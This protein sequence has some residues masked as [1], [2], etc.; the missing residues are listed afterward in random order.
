M[1][2]AL[3]EI[4]RINRKARKL[5]FNVYK[6]PK[7]ERNT[8][9]KK[10]GRLNI[11][12]M[13]LTSKP[14]TIVIIVPVRNRDDAQIIIKKT[15]EDSNTL[16]ILFVKQNM[17]LPFCRGAMLNIGFR[18][19]KRIYPME[20]G[21]ITLVLHDV[22][23]IPLEATSLHRKDL[24]KRWKT[25]SNIVKHIY[26]FQNSLGGIISIIASDFEKING[27]PNIYGW[28]NED[29][30]FQERVK[31][32]NIIENDEE[33]DIVDKT[34]IVRC[35][36]LQLNHDVC[37]ATNPPYRIYLDSESK[38][39][40]NIDDGC[41][42]ESLEYEIESYNGQEIIVKSFVTNFR[43]IPST[44]SSNVKICSKIKLKPEQIF[45]KIENNTKP[46]NEGWYNYSWNENLH[47]NFV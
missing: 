41:S 29:V 16:K 45:N 37:F 42:F 21:N 12:Q 9:S 31:N 30:C 5:E 33:G 34:K 7:F 6:I 25:K 46:D 36:T 4:E 38:K 22:D 15:Y 13:A 3:T 2:K 14:P 28:G 11:Y 26:G 24:V 23:V 35:K 43:E 1:T 17:G 19:I 32:N 27:F 20:Y 8:K 39:N 44:E 40:D 47:G 10:N 18:E